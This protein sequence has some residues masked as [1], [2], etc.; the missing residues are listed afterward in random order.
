MAMYTFCARGSHTDPGMY[1]H[2]CVSGY[3]L[4]EEELRC[5]NGYFR[6][7]PFALHLQPIVDALIHTLP[8]YNFQHHVI[9]NPLTTYRRVV[10]SKGFGS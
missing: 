7:L 2:A 1:M 9:A 5:H 10:R 3:L 6:K 4:G 8:I